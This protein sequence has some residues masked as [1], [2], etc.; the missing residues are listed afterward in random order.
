MIRL[1]L[2]QFRAQAWV[3]IGLLLLTAALLA[4]TGPHLAH[5]YG[6][7]AKAQAA[8]AASSDCGDVN[9]SI[10]KLDELL[11]LIGTALVAVPGLIGAFWGAPLISRELEHGTH[12]L[13]WTQSVSRTRWLAVKLALV[14]AASVAATGLLSLMVTWWSSPMDHADM[15]RF[16]AGLFGERNLTPLGYA[17][18]G[19]ALGVTAGLLIRRTL[20][21]MATTLAVF[22]GGRLTFT[23]FVRQHLLAPAHLTTPL[24]SVVQGFGQD[25][26]GPPNLFAG[27]NLPGAWVYSTRIVDGSG[28]GLTSQVVASSCPALLNPPPGNPGPSAGRAVAVPDGD[29]RDALQACVTKLSS[30]YHGVVTYQPS[31]RY[32]ILQWY[33]T[34]IFVA[35]AAGLAA[36]C[37]YV[38]RHRAG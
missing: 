11:K 28:R 5:L 7:Y 26:N 1:S 24:G 18:F 34:G 22:L 14:G 8:C 9:I 33:E 17:A 30:A 38:I 27:A 29:A 6:A 4:S 35:A 25:N 37:F 10:G 21:A 12:R 20:P 13:A 31:S 19:F 23:Y 32:W 15:N 36:V 16:G 3:A 2:R